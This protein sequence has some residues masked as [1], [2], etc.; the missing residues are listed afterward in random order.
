MKRTHHCGELRAAQVGQKVTLT[1]WVHVRRDLGGIVFIELRDRGG[2]TQVVFDPQ[3]NKP[4]WELAQSLRS[5]F[6]VAVEGTVRQRPA[7]TENPKMV[8]GEV[9]VLVH[10]LDILNPSETPPFQIDESGGAQAGEDLRLQYRYLDL[11]R[12][13]MARNLVLRHRIAKAVRDYFDSNGFLEVET[14]LLFKSTPEGAREYL[15]PS[16]VN[17]G[18]FYALPQSPQQ[19]KQ[20]LM[21][22]GVDRYFQIAKCFRDEDLR[23]DRQPEFTQVD[24]EMS[25][26]TREDVLAMIEG[27]VAHI[28]KVARNETLPTPFP[29]MVY[30]EAMERFGSDKPD[31]RFGIEL[32][33]LTKDFAQSQFKV[34]RGAVDSGGVVKAI[35]AKGL[36]SA[37]QGQIETLTETAKSFGAKGLAYIKV[38]RGEWKSPIVKFFSETEKKAL[39][40]KL[41]IEEGDL[42]LFGADKRET[43]WEVLGRLRL[44]VADILKKD[45]KLTVRDDQWDFLWI[46]DFPLLEYRAED[47]KYFARQHPFTAAVPEDVPMLDTEPLKVRGLQYDLV[48]NGQEMAGGSIRIHQP[49]VQKKM[50]HDVLRIPA[51]VAESRFGYMLQA[52]KYG[53]PP[54]GGIALGFDRLCA[55]LCGSTNI[56]DVIAFPKTAK[57]V[58]LMASSPSEVESKQLRDLH[59][60]LDV[61]DA[62]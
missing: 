50:F 31:T 17:P 32:V 21:V 11:R 36:A 24:V 60:K 44:I 59:I 14:P 54:H 28:W 42:I 15:V 40:E 2:H 22:A 3:H 43:V 20:M 25:F 27:L 5:E 49:S 16:R 41:K 62:G 18:K 9:E 48:L 12:P 58:D 51:E 47:Q 35:N 46:I 55:I 29:R 39:G 56:R 26:V 13:P 1:G 30:Q 38:E 6:V 37:T 23:A 52:F 53:A 8:T 4:S 57:A 19:F 7:G 34:F 45:G 61:E 10:H 33:D